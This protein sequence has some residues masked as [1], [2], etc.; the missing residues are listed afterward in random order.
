RDELRQYGCERGADRSGH[1]RSLAVRRVESR[2]RQRALPAFVFW[3]GSRSPPRVVILS[4]AKEPSPEAWLL[5]FAQ[6]DEGSE[7]ATTFQIIVW[8]VARRPAGG[9]P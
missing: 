3:D 1:H 7:F 8:I 9:D 6:D 4:E 2:G 5:R